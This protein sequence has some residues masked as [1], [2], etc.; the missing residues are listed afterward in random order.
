MIGIRVRIRV[1]LPIFIVGAV[2][3]RAGISVRSSNDTIRLTFRC[4]ANYGEA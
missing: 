2:I 3:V 4:S 1:R